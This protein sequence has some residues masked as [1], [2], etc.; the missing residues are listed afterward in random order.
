MPHEGD[1]KG[2]AG[3]PLGKME[4]EL[5]PKDS[6]VKGKPGYPSGSVNLGSLPGGSLGKEQPAPAD[7]KSSATRKR[8]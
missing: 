1:V 6:S 5:F 7:S 2:L 3:K 4:Q 8:K